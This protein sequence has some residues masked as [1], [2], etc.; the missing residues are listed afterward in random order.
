MSAACPHLPNIS[1][2]L[3][4]GVQTK[5]QTL[6]RMKCSRVESLHNIL[7]RRISVGWGGGS[8]LSYDDVVHIRMLS[9]V[10]RGNS[11]GNT[12]FELFSASH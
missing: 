3:R 12:V 10:Y 7:S 6:L 11:G 1:Q 8:F 2:W 9:A 5:F 4:A